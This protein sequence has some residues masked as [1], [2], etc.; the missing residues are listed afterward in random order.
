MKKS[1][2]KRL[3]KEVYMNYGS[4]NA[5]EITPGEF[6]SQADELVKKIIS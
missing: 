3:I 4:T 5:Y 6:R 1:E 2:L